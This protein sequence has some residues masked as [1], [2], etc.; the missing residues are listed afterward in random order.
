M[1]FQVTEKLIKNVD[2]KQLK[3]NK[4]LSIHKQTCVIECSYGNELAPIK[5]DSKLEDEENTCK[6]ELNENIQNNIKLEKEID[7]VSIVKSPKKDDT[8][9]SDDGA[10]R[11]EDSE[12]DYVDSD[13]S[14][15]KTLSALKKTANAAEV[16]NDKVSDCWTYSAGFQF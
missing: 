12:D 15:D 2:R 5:F 7:L 14:D 16:K 1:Y 8:G 3:L 9:V 6:I 13:C 4:S 11:Y 10:M